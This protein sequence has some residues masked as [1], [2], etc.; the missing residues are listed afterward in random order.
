MPRRKSKPPADIPFEQWAAVDQARGYRIYYNEAAEEMDIQSA[1][2]RSFLLMYQIGKGPVGVDAE[3]YRRDQAA[4]AEMNRARAAKHPA[5]VRATSILPKRE[6]KPLSKMPDYGADAPNRRP[7]LYPWLFIKDPD[8]ENGFKESVGPVTAEHLATWLRSRGVEWV[9][10][11]GERFLRHFVFDT[12]DS[13]ITEPPTYSPAPLP[14]KRFE[15]TDRLWVFQRDA[16]DRW[17]PGMNWGEMMSAYRSKQ[18]SA[19]SGRIGKQYRKSE[20]A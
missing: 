20:T 18:V 13:K 16:L 1:P 10:A 17:F 6:P 5:K 12:D 4:R 2:G 8:A 15:D 14:A 7:D 19:K 3:Q 11:R 9:P